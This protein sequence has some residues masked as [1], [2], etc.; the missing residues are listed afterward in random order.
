MGDIKG[1]LKVKRHKSQYRPIDTR[2]KDYAEVTLSRAED[3][4]QR[5]G[6]AL[7]GLRHSFLPLGL[8][9]G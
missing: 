3:V 5:A 1:F 4:S 2:L 9:G 8:P 6:V 7:Y